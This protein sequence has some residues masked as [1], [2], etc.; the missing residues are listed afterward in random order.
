MDEWHTWI[1]TLRA[2]PRGSQVLS[3]KYMRSIH[4][5]SIVESMEIGI[6]YFIGGPK[7]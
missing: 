7:S 3:P 5:I 4:A 2:G 1:L 6:Y